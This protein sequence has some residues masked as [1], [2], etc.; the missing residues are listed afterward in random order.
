[1]AE[2]GAEQVI[3]YRA[4]RFEDRVKEVDVVFDT[5]GGETLQRSWGAEAGRAYGANCRG[6]RG[7]VRRA[8]QATFFIV[9]PIQKQLI[10]I[11]YLLES[12]HLR[13]MVDAVRRSMHSLPCE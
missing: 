6:K 11:G 1:V 7:V 12:G 9:E 13:P 8:I 3:D 5:V 4:E 10:E 2:S